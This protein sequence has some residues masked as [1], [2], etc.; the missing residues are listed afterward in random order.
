MKKYFQSVGSGVETADWGS[1]MK[2][3][4]N[5]QFHGLEPSDAMENSVREHARKL[6]SLAPDIMACRV[7]IDLAHKHK[8]QGRQFGVRIDLTL[9]GHE[10]VVNHVQHEDAHIALRDAFEKMKRQLED[11]VR[12]RQAIQRVVPTLDESTVEDENEPEE[13]EA[14]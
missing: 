10:L 8:H 11:V 13:P 3:P 12:K 9:P 5:I 1:L 14:S 7:S 2:L 4:V 6:D